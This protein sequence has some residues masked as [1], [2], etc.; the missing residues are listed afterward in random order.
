MITEYTPG[1]HHQRTEAEQAEVKIW[2]EKRGYAYNS[3]QKVALVEGGVEIEEMVRDANGKP[4]LA[5]NGRHLRVNTTKVECV[6]PGWWP[7]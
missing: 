3:V 6:R 4:Q 5:G 2:L 7:E 1:V